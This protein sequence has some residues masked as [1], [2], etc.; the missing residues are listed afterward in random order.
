GEDLTITEI[1]KVCDIP[2]GTVKSRMF[3]ALNAI[4]E[5]CKLNEKY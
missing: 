4:R 3:S 1:A 2:E 5:Y